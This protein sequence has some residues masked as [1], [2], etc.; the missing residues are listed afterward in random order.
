QNTV[1]YAVAQALFLIF[2]FRW[3]DLLED[4]EEEEVPMKGAKSEGGGR[5]KKWM[6]QLDVVQRVVNSVLNPLKVCSPNVASQ[7]A[8]VAHA[9]DFLYCY[10][11][12]ESN[13]RS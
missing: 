12:L 10:T 6:K 1:F 9:T 13:R 3:R 11:I 5:G 4:G 2:C 7:F 8:R